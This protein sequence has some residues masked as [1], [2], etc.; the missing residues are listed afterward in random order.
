MLDDQLDTNTKHVNTRLCIVI[1]FIY[2]IEYLMFGKCS[3]VK[4]Q[5]EVIT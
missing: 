5:M 3:D 4:L 1:V 2:N